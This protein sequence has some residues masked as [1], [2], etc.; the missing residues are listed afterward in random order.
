MH[1]LDSTDLDAVFGARTG[2]LPGDPFV[3]LDPV[4]PVI[5]SEPAPAGGGSV[6]APA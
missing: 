6:P 5:T 3:Y 2:S 1:V 4:R